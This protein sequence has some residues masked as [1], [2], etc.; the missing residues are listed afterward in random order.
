MV[1]ISAQLEANRMRIHPDPDPKHCA[2]VSNRKGGVRAGGIKKVYISTN[3]LLF[4]LVFG[5]FRS[6]RNT[7]TPCFDIEAKQLKHMSCL[8]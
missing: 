4:Q 8:E 5:L 1:K 2:S 3:L 6:F 7:E